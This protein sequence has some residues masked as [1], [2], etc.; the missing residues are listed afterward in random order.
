[1]SAE[2]LWQQMRALLRV[3]TKPVRSE[4]NSS[5][6]RPSFISSLIISII[7]IDLLAFRRIARTPLRNRRPRRRKRTNGKVGKVAQHETTEL[8]LPMPFGLQRRSLRVERK[9]VLLVAMPKQLD[10]CGPRRQLR[11]QVSE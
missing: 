11:M 8:P 4:R 5:M 7:A 10:V 9:R 6:R 2:L 1:M 3:L